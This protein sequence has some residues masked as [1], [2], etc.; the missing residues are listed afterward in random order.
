M[1]TS[2]ETFIHPE[3]HASAYGVRA[4]CL[5]V[6]ALAALT[7][8]CTLKVIPYGRAIWDFLFVLDGAYRISLGQMPHVDFSSPIGSLTLYLTLTAQNL[9]PGG[10][11][12][13]GLHVLMWLLLLPPMA[14][15]A[16]RFNSSAA[17][18]AAFGLF[19]LIVL[20]PMTL[21][22]THLSEISYFAS[23]NR[24]ATGLLF[25]AGLWF[26]LPKSRH[27]WLLLAYVLLLLF[28][29]K[30]TAAAV[31]VGL[32]LAAVVL[33]RCSLRCAA[34]ALAAFAVALLAIQAVTGLVSAYL[35]DIAAM[36]GLNKGGAV[37]A[38]AFAGF[39]NW[40]ALAI[41]GGLAIATLVAAPRAGNH[42]RL[43]PVAVL[44]TF[45]NREAYAVDTVLLVAAALFAESQ[46]TGGLGLIAAAAVLFHPAAWGPR[47]IAPALLLAAICFP[48]IDIAVKRSFT[49]VTRE[50]DAAPVQALAE[51]IPGTRVP[52]ATGEGARLF[53]RIAQEWLPLARQVDAAGFFLTPD[54]TT[55][56][57]AVQLAWATSAVEAAHVF[58]QR[59]YRS[60]A[61][62]YATLAFADPFARLLHLSPAKGTRLVMDVGRTIPAF[63][64]DQARTYLA[65]ADGAFLGTCD[66]ARDKIRPV[67]EP[68]LRKDF[69]RLPLTPCW[70]FYVRGGKS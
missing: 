7:A 52:L 9:F 66:M 20:L 33:G 69:E 63:S 41:T 11:A 14:A 39:R 22:S 53:A 16:R 10:N 55:N 1:S 27:D 59:G 44:R 32:L 37:Y 8:A 67:F 58:E 51:M 60:R 56:A 61:T 34:W 54:P 46:N 5:I 3:S 43:R 23:Y 45:F 29:L 12:F 65:A 31:A 25:L 42:A 13:V 4:A 64:P 6:G 21:D 48:L 49:A 47:R 28:F 2:S 70:D 38:L 24:F 36:S 35:A 40:L 57:P 50:R 18:F 15:L 68:I 30:I 26:V 17:F 62:S 19:A